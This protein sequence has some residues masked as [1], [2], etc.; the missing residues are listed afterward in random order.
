MKP[1]FQVTDHFR[2]AGLDTSAPY[3]SM[4]SVTMGCDAMSL[5]GKCNAD[6]N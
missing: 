6:V 2:E 5:G 3:L 1:F 4:V